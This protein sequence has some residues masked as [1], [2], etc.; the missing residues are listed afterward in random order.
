MNTGMSIVL[1]RAQQKKNENRW[2]HRCYGSYRGETEVFLK[3]RQWPKMLQK[4][5]SLHEIIEKISIAK[6]NILHSIGIAL[7]HSFG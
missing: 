7:S 3:C 2:E 5:S 6:V 4:S 1:N